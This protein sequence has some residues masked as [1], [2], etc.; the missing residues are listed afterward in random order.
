MQEIKKNGGDPI[1]DFA[2]HKKE[3]ERREA[4]E[5]KKQEDEKEWYRT[6]REAFEQAYPDV[7]LT[8]LIEDK[9]FQSFAEG[10][11]GTV[12]LK[13]IYEKFLSFTAEYEKKAQSKAAQMV[14]NAKASPGALS[15][16]GESGEKFFTRDEINA[17]SEKQINENW[18]AIRKSMKR[19]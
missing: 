5:R 4:D 7:S 12:P 13:D 3:R 9:T 10:K 19:W 17:M 16:A 6:D 11:V 2:K 14:A 1:S 15:S 18:D 8:D